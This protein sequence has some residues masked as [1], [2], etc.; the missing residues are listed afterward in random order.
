MSKLDLNT[1]TVAELRKIAK[2]RGVT[3]GAGIQKAGIIAKLEAA[4]VDEPDEAPAAQP[5]AAPAPA[6]QAAPSQDKAPA[7]PAP[8]APQQSG[9][10]MFRAA[11]H[12]PTPRYNSK[13]AYT[14]PQRTAGGYQG[15]QRSGMNQDTPPRTG[16]VRPANYTPR[17]GPEAG[18]EAAPAPRQEE[19]YRSG[20]YQQPARP[21][22]QE[23]RPAYGDN[24]Y[25]QQ[26]GGFG[27]QQQNYDQRHTYDQQ[28][29]GYD[30]RPAYDNRSADYGQPAYSQQSGYNQQPGYDQRPAYNNQAS[31]G[32][33]PAYNQQQRGSNN[34]YGDN[35]AP[36]SIS[37]NELLAA[38]DCQDSSGVLELHPDGYGFLRAETFQPSSK[39]I[40]I[41]MAQIK[42]FGLR[43]GDLVTG[44]TRPQRDGDKYTAMLYITEINGVDPEELTERAVFDEL[45]ICYPAKRMT[46]NG[47][48][49]KLTTLRT[50]DLVAP[51][52]FGQRGLLLCPPDFNKTDLLRD[53]ANALV[54]HYPDVT[55]M[56]LLIDKCPEDVS[57]FRDQTKCSVLASTFNQPPENHLRLTDM[58]LERAQ[59]LVELGK[60]VVIVVDSLTRLAKTFTTAAAQQ[61]RSMPGQVNPSSLFRA[62]KLFGAARCIKNG[63]SLTIIGAMDIETGSKVDDAVVEEFK[64]T[65]NLELWFDGSLARTGVNP[66]IN[67]MLT[68][69]K[70]EETL[71]TD[72]KQLEGLKLLRAS[73]SGMSAPKA[74]AQ[75]TNLITNTSSNADL[76]LKLKDWLNIVKDGKVL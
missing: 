33:H 18:V 37:L 34:Y 45:P 58:V 36:V 3:L 73:I 28:R 60:D 21:A 16:T 13:P 54:E 27:P 17:F 8:A 22:Y 1:K 56:V 9:G 66:P 26:R 51:M 32:Q 19:E 64:G 24:A 40:Y 49:E 67:L 52:G 14:A 30:N 57:L 46:F 29:Q 11:W 55:T 6:P 23:R 70:R 61:G 42:R 38:G 72:P 25:G 53:F 44:K 71:L 5:E 12:N 43:T 7:A 35:N 59:R 69:T 39:D 50:A 20:S 15:T 74:I 76:L 2:D 4:M 75:I 31:Y 62:K 65:A 41:S 47:Q 10:T 63:G 48:S 68:G